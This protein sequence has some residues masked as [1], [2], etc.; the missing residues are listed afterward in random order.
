MDNK[1]QRQSIT[2]FRIKANRRIRT[3]L[4]C[5]RGFRSEGPHNRRCPRCN[6]RLEQ[7]REGSYYEPS[8]YSTEGGVAVDSFGNS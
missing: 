3:C 7:A 6:R 1:L 2:R 8:V 4:M 5:G